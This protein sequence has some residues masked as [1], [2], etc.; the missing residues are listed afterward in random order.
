MY[1]LRRLTIRC[2]FQVQP[3]E[4]EDLVLTHPAVSEVSMTSVFDD[5]DATEVPRAFVVR[6][7]SVSEKSKLALEMRQ[8]VDKKVAGYKRLFGGVS[9]VE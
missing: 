5:E 3:A 1:I 8:I 9:F 7:W 2:R 4:L 6:T